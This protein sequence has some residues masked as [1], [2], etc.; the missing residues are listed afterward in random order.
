MGD[1]GLMGKVIL[2]DKDFG[3]LPSE[4]PRKKKVVL[5]DKDVS[6]LPSEGA[7]E[8]SIGEDILEGIG[9]IGE[10][11]DR[12][13]GAPVRAAVGAAQKGEPILEAGYEQIGE[14]TKHAP[15]GKEIMQEFGVSDEPLIEDVPYIGDISKSGAAGFAGEMVMDPLMIAGAGIKAAGMAARAIKPVRL[16]VKT[17]AGKA[18]FKA[19][20]QIS[21]N[22]K[23]KEVFK[24]NRPQIVGQQLLESDLGQ[25][26]N[27]PSL[28]LEKIKGKDTVKYVQQKIGKTRVDR[29]IKTRT[30]GMIS[31]ISKET[32][33]VLLKIS[34]DVDKIDVNEL[35]EQLIN[36]DIRLRIN[37]EEAIKF[38]QK[39]ITRYEKH[40]TELLKPIGDSG[41]M[42]SVVQLQNL[43]KSIGKKLSSKEFFAPTDRKLALEKNAMLDI[44]HELKRTI[45]NSIEGVSV[46]MGDDIVDAGVLVGTNNQKVTSLM[47]VGALLENIP[48]K[49]MRS[50]TT[51]QKITDLMTSGAIGLGVAGASGSTAAG[52]VAAGAYGASRVGT[53]IAKKLPA[54]EANVLFNFIK[55]EFPKKAAATS[56]IRS[57]NAG[58]EPQSVPEQFIRTPLP[59]NTD[60][61]LENREFVLGK[62]AQMAP[63]MFDQL[64]DLMDNDPDIMRDTLPL[65]VQQMPHL[66]A[67]DKY[68]RVDGKIMD[69]EMRVRAT[70][71]TMNRD[72]LSNHDK[73]KMISDLN[74]TGEFYDR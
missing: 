44:Y 32:E 61:I 63:E 14:P 68:N 12:Y 26:L 20:S 70:K 39:D 38:S 1:G 62:T 47:D 35:A 22:S 56:V 60:E 34:P 6:A 53:T 24:K 23:I 55:G 4:S 51:V 8:T 28:L 73:I 27:N 50:H 16:A 72:D 36:K 67:R 10:Y 74:K 71:D 18:A 5:S 64:K 41:D 37:P 40:I 13:T 69:P 21:D 49:E 19:L 52:M 66:F 9:T 17:R 57:M 29:P 7:E 2:S 54:V 43:K 31:D 42:R 48:A 65:L 3:A 25:Y 45:E 11:I 59:R 15:T 46:Q 58:R 30:G 33:E